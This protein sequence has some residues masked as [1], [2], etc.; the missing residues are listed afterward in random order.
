MDESLPAQ[1]AIVVWSAVL[2]FNKVWCVGAWLAWSLA[3]G[4][5]NVCVSTVVEL[6]WYI[7]A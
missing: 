3:C 1:W 7:Y 2:L 5:E 6:L 4:A